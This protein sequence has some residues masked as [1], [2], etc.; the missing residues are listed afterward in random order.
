MLHGQ[1]TTH[2]QMSR[3]YLCTKPMPHFPAIQTFLLSTA[4]TKQLAPHRIQMLH[5]HYFRTTS[6][7]FPHC[8][9]TLSALLPHSIRALS[10]LYPC[11]I[12]TLSAL[13]PRS[14]RALSALYPHSI[15]ALSALFP[16]FIAIT[17]HR[18]L[19]LAEGEAGNF[20]C[21]VA[22]GGDFLCLVAPRKLPR[23]CFRHRPH[24]LIVK[25][26]CCSSS[27]T[28]ILIGCRVVLVDH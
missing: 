28:S 14:I 8:F 10:A 19:H 17:P 16:H 22:Q 4:L 11:S 25:S 5:P 27:T 21:F 6:A 2:Q 3:N 9:R 13:L 26:R 7:L 20:L 23:R 24:S 1:H 15:R 12:R 18:T